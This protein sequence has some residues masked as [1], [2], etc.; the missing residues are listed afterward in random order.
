MPAPMSTDPPRLAGPARRHDL[1][2]L[3][4]AAMLLG[5]V[6][7]GLLAF[8]DVPWPVQDIERVPWLGLPLAWIHGFRMQLFF[9]ISGFFTAMLWRRRGL[10]GLLRHRGKRIGLPF[11]LGCATIVPLTWAIVIWATVTAPGPASASV[12]DRGRDVW[13]AAAWGETEAMREHLAGGAAIDGVD[14]VFGVP[15]LGWAAATGRVSAVD[16]LIELGADPNGLGSNGSTPLHVA[17]FFGRAGASARLLAAGADPTL[18]NDA[19]ERVADVLDVDRGGTVFIARLMQVPI[20]VDAVDAGREEVRTQLAAWESAAPGAEV[21]SAEAAEGA[22][23]GTPASTS[24]GPVRAI[25]DGLMWFP[26][27]HHLWFLWFLCWMVAGFALVILLA[28]RV[29]GLRN[30][31]AWSIAVAIPFTLGMQWF[32][33]ARGTL[34]G[35]GPDTSAGLLPVPHVLAYHGAFFAVGAMLFRGGAAGEAARAS[36]PA[37]RR[38]DRA[39]P[40]SLLVASAIFMPSLMLSAEPDW[41]ADTIGNGSLRHWLAATGQVLFAWG[42]IHG[43]LGLGR[44]VLAAERPW[45]RYMSDASYWLYLAHLPVIM[46]GQLLVRNAS[47]PWAAKLGLNIVLTTGLLLGVYAIVVRPTWIGRMLNGPRAPRI[48]RA[49]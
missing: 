42:M 13:T 29:S 30:P 6:L 43:V 16:A 19:N 37:G 38:F 10:G 11:A 20:D 17:A 9:L 25:L 44:R 47:L 35:F 45:V 48:A 2:A 39:W 12:T 40:I 26:L 3:R 41:A 8:V 28:G 32:M 33:H 34:P 31:G 14:P 49:S 27:F 23:A 15:P 21:G 46:L 5:I 1:D 36:G 24:T 18:R 22:D 7:H 4:A